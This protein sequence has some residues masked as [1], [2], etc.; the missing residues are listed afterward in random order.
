MTARSR[1]LLAGFGMALLAAGLLTACAT[2][3]GP[4]ASSTPSGSPSASP[5][6][7]LE[8]DAAWVD[9][10]RMV[11]LV[12]EGSS[13]C[14]PAAGETTYADG[15]LE[16]ELL[17]PPDDTACTADYVP[18]A[19]LAGVPE[20]VDPAQDL[21]IRLV[22]DYRGGTELDGVPGLEPAAEPDYE[23]SA[24]WADDGQF[25]IVTWGSSTCPPVLENV[26]ATSATEVTVTFATP[27]EDQACTLDM[28]PRATIAQVTT[29][30]DDDAETFAILTGADFD[31]VRVPIIGHD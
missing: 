4:G 20:G 1:S 18:R 14:I 26:E 9:G 23:P 12:T 30:F 17:D 19:T 15:V 25:V 31:S 6:K 5:G 24:G 29:E 21:E 2:P 10:G 8:V 11:A 16:V 13:G 22:G 3:A 27:P 28:A 7:E